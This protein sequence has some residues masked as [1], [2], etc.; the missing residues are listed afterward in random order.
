MRTGIDLVHYRF[1]NQQL[2]KTT[3]RKPEALVRWM[4]AV[5]AQDYHG[6]L[7][8]IG[9]RLPGITKSDIE[10]AISERKIVRTWSMRGT[11]HFVP[12]SD[13]KWMLELLTPRVIKKSLGRYKE[14]GL[15]DHIFEQSKRLFT[16]ALTGKQLTRNELYQVLANGKINPEGQRGYHILSHLAQ[17]AFICHST[18]QG[19]QPR[20]ALFDE[21]I[22]RSKRLN[23]NKALAELARRYFTSHGPATLQ[24][25]TWWSGLTVADARVG[26]TS[27]K[28]IMNTEIDGRTYFLTRK[29]IAKIPLETHLLPPYDEYFISYKDRSAVINA[30]MLKGMHIA[31]TNSPLIIKGK[32]IGIW[33]R[34]IKKNGLAIIAK[35]FVSL[36]STE[37]NSLFLAAERY[38]FFLGTPVTLTV[39]NTENH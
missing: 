8:G 32:V 15:H 18:R 1:Y 26:I 7:W 19:H 11:L 22:P 23:R 29:T 34:I 17:T 25:F 39:E 6:G 16:K 31:L 4:G 3:F 38:S 27:V 33:K 10:Q 14:L 2:G 24:D 36:N 9:L 35:L 21:W 37:K 20:F 28:E 13:A 5:Q 30:N 12:A